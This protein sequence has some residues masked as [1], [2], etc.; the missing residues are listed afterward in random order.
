[1]LRKF[2]LQAVGIGV[3]GH[4]IQHLASGQVV[5]FLNQGSLP[6]VIQIHS[7]IASLKNALPGVDEGLYTEIIWDDDSS[8][9]AGK[10]LAEVKARDWPQTYAA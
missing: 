8:H 10:G 7:S 5:V 9:P 1:M 4:G 2:Y 3:V 6:G